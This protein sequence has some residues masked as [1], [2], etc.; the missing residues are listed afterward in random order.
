M[1]A[2]TKTGE[3]NGRTTTTLPAPPATQESRLEEL[4][5]L[6]RK[7]CGTFKANVRLADGTTENWTYPTYPESG[8]DA[9]LIAA[10]PT[11]TDPKTGGKF[12]DRGQVKGSGK[13][14]LTE[15]AEKMEY[16]ALAVE[17][18]VAK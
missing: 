18:G 15:D 6:R 4:K 8:T 14:T 7:H 5:R 17:L 12:G 3:T 10:A 1:A 16:V 2:I 13:L 9:G 11:I